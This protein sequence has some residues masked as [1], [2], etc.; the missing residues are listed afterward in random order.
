MILIGVG[1]AATDAFVILFMALEVVPFV[2]F[3]AVAL[4][5]ILFVAIKVVGRQ[6]CMIAIGVATAGPS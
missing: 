5:V 2:A 4:K 3:K 1:V 6:V